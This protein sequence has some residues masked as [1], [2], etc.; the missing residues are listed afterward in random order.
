MAC[1]W[2]SSSE[3]AKYFQALDG[4]RHLSQWYYY[5]EFTNRRGI[6]QAEMSPAANAGAYDWRRT[7]SAFVSARSYPDA[8]RTGVGRGAPDEAAQPTS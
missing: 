8:R 4:K 3:T 7:Q 2:H 1:V 6:V 5:T